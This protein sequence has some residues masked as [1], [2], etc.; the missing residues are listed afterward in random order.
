MINA[1]DFG[2]HLKKIEKKINRKL[3]SIELA[4]CENFYGVGRL[5]ELTKI[6]KVNKLF[7]LSQKQEGGE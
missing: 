2:K 5:H 4:L 6:N 3:D 1:T 7:A